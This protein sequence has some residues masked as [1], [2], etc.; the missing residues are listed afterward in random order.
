MADSQPGYMTKPE[1]RKS[2]LEKRRSLSVGEQSALG[3]KIADRFFEA[4]DLAAVTNL[5]IFIHIRKFNEVDT[6]MIFYRVWRDFPHVR[7]FA[8][9]SDLATGTIRDVLFDSATAFEENRW[10]IREP[11]SGETIEPAELDVAIVP[12]LAFDKEGHRVGYGKG[13][14]DRHLA[15]C[16]PDCVKIGVGYFG[17]VA[18]MIE[19]TQHDIPMDM[20]VT[21]DG[22]FRFGRQP[23]SL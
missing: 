12:M 2:Y 22:I 20:C 14:Y 19:P 6:S 11:V 3:S 8:P 4:V 18:G 7:T 15:A 10:E 9:K 21:P 1:L 23:L 5:H 13:F 17:P 16:R